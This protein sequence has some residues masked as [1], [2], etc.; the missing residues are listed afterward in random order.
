MGE[1]IASTYEIVDRIG[2]GGGG[3]VYLA[4]HLRLG[5]YV[6]LKADK[7]KITTKPEIL[8]R[9]VDV[10]KNL[11]HTYIPQVYDFFVEGDTVY[12]AMDYIEGESL[13]KPLKR[14]E[15][16][17][18]PQV[19]AFA[20]ELLEALAYL[21][22]PTHGTP[23]HGIVH[24]DI[25]PA[26]IMLT[27]SGHI[28]LIDYNIALAIGEENVVG[29][30]AGYASPEHYGLDFSTDTPIMNE[31]TEVMDDSAATEVMQ[32]SEYTPSSKKLIIPDVRSDIYSLGATLYHLLSGRRP[33]KDAPEVVPLSGDNIS[34]QIVGIISKSMCPN[35]DLRYQSAEEMLD[36][37]LNLR[38]NDPRTKRLNKTRNAVCGVLSLAVLCGAFTSFTGLKRMELTQKSLTLAEYA[39]TALAEGEREQAISYAMQAL[40]QATG[41]FVP[42]VTAEAQKAL[43]DASGIYDLSDG[44]KAHRMVE[45]PSETLKT[46]ISPSG[47]MGAAVYAFS[48]ALFDTETGVIKATLPTVE[49]AL[50]DVVFLDDNTIVY[51]GENGI[52]AYDI[53]KE[54][55]LWVGNQATAIAV[56]ADKKVI[57]AL[58]KDEDFATLYASDGTVKKTISFAGKRQRVVHNDTFADPLDNIFSLSRDGRFLAV[59]FS[60]GGLMVYDAEQPDGDVELYLNSDYTHFEGGFF[61]KYFA[62]SST[63]DAESVFSVIDLEEYMQVG[64]FALT[65]KI[66]IVANET[67]I[68]LSN[69][70]ITVKIDPETGEQ[71]EMAY[72]DADVKLFATDTKNTIVATEKN[73]YVIFDAAANLMEQKNS[74]QTSCDFVDISGDYALMAGRDTPKIKILKRKQHD[75]ATLLEYDA[76]Y[77]HNEARTN[78]E[79]T[80]MMLFSYLGF[81]LFDENG[82]VIRDVTFPDQDMIYDQQYCKQSGNL[83]VMYET[84]FS[85]YS[86]DTGELLV[87]ETDAKSVF[88]APYGVS[89]LDANNRLKLYDLD[90][91]EILQE[92]AVDGDFG[93]WCGI[94]IDRDFLKN[95]ELIGAAKSIDGYVFAVAVAE[96]CFVYNEKG[97]MMFTVPV[98]PQSE[99]FFTQKEIILSPLHG[100]PTVYSLNN[101]RKVADLEQDTY[102]TY[103]TETERYIVSSYI[104][105]SGEQFAHLLDK[106][107]FASLAYL[108]KLCDVSDESLLFNDYCGH[109]RGS[110]IY[111]TNEIMNLL[112]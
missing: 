52:S 93:A 63:K 25:K 9:E 102:L 58:Y 111:T 15:T 39:Q 70:N 31:T 107:T 55:N 61:G 110:K 8:R 41:L 82:N 68:Y 22:S 28:C 54:K 30:S 16:F 5:K 10:L 65:D 14:G 105:A 49:S 12:T 88:Y 83:A 78:R 38:K 19:I 24:S 56:S 66:G 18:Q 76:S 69:K 79:K 77:L 92:E 94:I 44:F 33:A 43:A 42:S 57:A 11:S 3:I 53:D 104:S 72:T 100:T 62:F 40:P 95:G 99:A 103:I 60:D 29:R 90:T 96:T 67:G 108:P 106:N 109:L 32:A 50:A 85:L 74:G 46:I 37:F 27:S 7:R 36:A 87:E 97:K 101:G 91:A 47:T 20:C 1:I 34:P 23:P 51:A 48:V 112:K 35:P 73:D 2:S 81:R 75:E 98:L 21:H 26:N 13:D 84:G 45:L 86:G 17:S 80:R 89:V 4:N 59:S 6:V 64:G 71:T